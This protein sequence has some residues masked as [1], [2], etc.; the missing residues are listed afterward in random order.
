MRE[1]PKIARGRLAAGQQSSPPH[2]DANLISAFVERSLLPCERDDVTAHLAACERCRAE[3]RLVLAAIPAQAREAE[4]GRDAASQARPWWRWT[5]HWQPVTAVAGLAAVSLIIWVSTRHPVR[6]AGRAAAPAPITMAS[7]TTQAPSAASPGPSAGD[8]AV[9]VPGAAPAAETQQLA[10]RATASPR[11]QAGAATSTFANETVGG[12]AGGAIADNTSAA[13][14]GQRE[15]PLSVAAPAAPPPA[16]ISLPATERP[17][18]AQGSAAS[19]EPVAA[20]VRGVAPAPA[21]LSVRASL[22]AAKAAPAPRQAALRRAEPAVRWAASATPEATS[23][24]AVE[25]SL[26]GGLTWQRVP[27][28]EGVTFRVVFALGSDVWAGG[29]AGAFFHSS[30]GGE[31]WSA[32]PLTSTGGTVAGDVISIQFADAAHGSVITSEGETWTT[33]DGGRHWQQVK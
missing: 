21:T 18:A 30:D 25:R 17:A 4:S 16:P 5:L 23:Q 13:T 6:Y 29:A 20:A 15:L 33:S 32:V 1:L 9:P 19:G 27:V 22:Y 7:K 10:K 31:H 3:V 8:K 2:L 11:P 24:G 28:S 26:D 12:I 14:A